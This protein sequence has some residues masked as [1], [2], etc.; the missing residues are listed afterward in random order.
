LLA[1]IEKKGIVEINAKRKRKLD[2]PKKEPP[3]SQLQHDATV[4]MDYETTIG[5]SYNVLRIKKI[6]LNE[7]RFPL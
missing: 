7:L 4:P 5:N 2:E 6:N 3:I 1:N